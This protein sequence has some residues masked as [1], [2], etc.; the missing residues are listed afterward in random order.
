MNTPVKIKNT[1][2]SWA[3][4]SIPVWTIFIVGICAFLAG[5]LLNHPVT[6]TELNGKYATFSRS[7][8][9]FQA[10]QDRQGATESQLKA[11]ITDPINLFIKAYQD[12]GYVVID[13]STDQD[14]NMAVLALP[15]GSID[16]SAELS[17]LLTKKRTN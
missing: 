9:I 2:E 13:N 16:V 1:V 17:Q 3:N 14:G 10:V 6:T 11:E 7:M 15:K 8:I 5:T 12:Q 4:F